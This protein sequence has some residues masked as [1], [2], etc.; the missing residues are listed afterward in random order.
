LSLPVDPNALPQDAETLK[1][2]LVDVTAQRDRTERLLRQLLQA[3]TGR[4]SEQLSREQLAL[5]ATELGITLPETEDSADDHDQ[6][7]PAGAAPSDSSTSRGRKPLLRHLKRER[8]EHDLPEQ[9]KRCAD[10]NQDLRKIGEEVSERYEY[11]PAQMKVIEDACFT[12]ACA[13]TVRMASKPPQP[14]EKSTGGASLLAQVIVSKLADHLPLHRQ[15]KMFRRHGIEIAEQTM[16]GWMA[17]CAELLHPLYERLKRNVLASE[18]VGTD[19]TPVKVLDR[20]L[21]HARKGRIWPYVGDREHPAVIYDYTATRERA[22]PEAFLQS[23]R[24]YLQADA[25]VAYDS[26]FLK[27]ERGMVEV[28]C[29]AH[30]RRHVYQALDHDPSRMRTLLLMIAELYGVEK[31]ARQ[32]GLSGED[33]RLLREQGARPVLEKLHAYLLQIH[34]ELLPKSEAGQAVNYL[35]KNWTAL[36]RYRENP[37]LSIDNNHTERSL[38][39]WAV[40]RN[41]W[42]FFGSDRGGRTAAVLRSFVASC[43]LVK[44][45]PFAWFQ[46]V[47][48]RIASH[49][50]T[51]LDEL[52]PDRWSLES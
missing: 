33:L 8:I 35:L 34:K 18:V 52:L 49:P 47:L 36:T 7:P 42:T 28:G 4:R 13:C 40:G 17:Q 48:S 26:F 30:A 31:L 20:R 23:Y 37:A 45:D 21:P 24:G 38:R 43:E 5:F 9:E 16:C 1:K 14:I 50:I 27:P 39:G 51:R 15:A 2:M 46:D 3:K 12:Y 11:L 32:R 10:C 6:D 41:N 22:G 19:D 29:W 25:Y 44:V